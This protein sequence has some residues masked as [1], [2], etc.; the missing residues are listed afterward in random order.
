MGHAVGEEEVE[1]CAATLAGDVLDDAAEAV[2]PNEQRERLV[3]VRWPGHQLVQQE[4]RCRDRDR[5]NPDPQRVRVE[6]RPCRGK[7]GAG[8]PGSFGGLC[9]R[10]SGRIFAGRLAP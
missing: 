1:R 2:A 8:A 6:K 5:A 4:R 9:H 3:L 10:P 7:G